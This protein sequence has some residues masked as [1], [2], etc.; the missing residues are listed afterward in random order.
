M[1]ITIE[2]NDKI[3]TS[4]PTAEVRGMANAAQLIAVTVSLTKQASNIETL[5]LLFGAAALDA[6]AT[7]LETADKLAQAA[8]GDT[9]SVAK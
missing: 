4:K 9:T 3:I 2:L 7:Q 1:K 6:I 5:M 8:T